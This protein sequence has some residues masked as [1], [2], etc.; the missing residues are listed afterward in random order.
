M[1]KTSGKGAA[2]A[3]A[4]GSLAITGQVIS[5]VLFTFLGYLTVGLPLAVLPGYVHQGLGFG[6]VVAGLAVSVQYVATLL[7]RSHAGR[8]ADTVGPKQTVLSGLM[9][10]AV[11]GVLL[12]LAY[13]FERSAWLSLSCLLLSRLVLGFGESWVGTGAI[14]WGIGKMGPDH[15]ARV[16]SWNGVCTYGA[17]AVGAPL[18]VYLVETWSFG[19]VGAMVLAVG[20]LGIALALPRAKV[21]VQGGVR[22]PFGNVVA[23]VLPHGMALALGSVGFGSIATFIT[24]YYAAHSWP[25]AALTLSIFGLSFIAVRLLLGRTIARFGGFPVAIASFGVEVVGLLLLWLAV[26]P[27]MA[28]VGAALTGCGFSLIFPSIGVEAV[29]RVPPGSRGSGLAVYSAFMDL[30][31]AVT[32]P[33]AGFIANGYGYPSIYLFASFGAILA[34]LTVLMLMRQTRRAAAQPA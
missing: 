24:L 4:Q 20:L 10:C 7:S 25:D 32:G 18:G 14:T 26:A 21:A 19:A 33:V 2:P 16:I 29:N 27:W 23:R 8:M 15:T 22:M 5:I 3:A 31:L 13:A 1:N 28:L 12:L 11:S 6:S 17:L 9:A 30:A 34:I